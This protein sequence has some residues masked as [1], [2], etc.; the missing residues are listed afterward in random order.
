[1][2]DDYKTGDNNQFFNKIWRFSIKSSN[3]ALGK[4][5]EVT[6]YVS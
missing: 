5:N 6:K 3:F 1:M 4:S 2:N